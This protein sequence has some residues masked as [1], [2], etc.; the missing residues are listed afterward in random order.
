MHVSQDL[1]LSLSLVCAHTHTNG[2]VVGLKGGL[3]M[4]RT[5]VFF[6]IFMFMRG[7]QQCD[8]C[9]WRISLA[10]A[11]SFVPHSFVPSPVAELAKEGSC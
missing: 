5:V 1:S 7:V 8:R 3:K 2:R 10:Y 9:Q 4:Q 6:I 11:H